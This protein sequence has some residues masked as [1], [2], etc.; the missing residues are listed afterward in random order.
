[1]VVE[2][3]VL[4]FGWE[5]GVYLLE[6]N[7]IVDININ[8]WM[9]GRTFVSSFLP[10]SSYGTERPHQIEDGPVNL[11]RWRSLLKNSRK[12]MTPGRQVDFDSMVFHYQPSSG[13]HHYQNG[14][15]RTQIKY[16]AQPY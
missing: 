1:V 9:D 12:N 7:R 4:C 6:P 16:V 15:R 14:Q 3:G 8:I 13:L 2:K 11:R 5:G 10:P